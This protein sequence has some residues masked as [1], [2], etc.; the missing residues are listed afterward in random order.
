MRHTYDVVY[1]RCCIKYIVCVCI[2]FLVYIYMTD[3]CAV[4]LNT[5]NC[6]KVCIYILHVCM[7]IYMK[8][9]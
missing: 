4:N 2:P 8:E 9:M 3:I 1:V 5:L 6:Y 7:H